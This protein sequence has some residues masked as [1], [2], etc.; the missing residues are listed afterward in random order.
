MRTGVRCVL[1]T[2]V[3]QLYGTHFTS[4]AFLLIIMMIA[5][6]GLMGQWF[7]LFST[8]N[9]SRW[10]P[11]GGDCGPIIIPSAGVLAMDRKAGWNPVVVSLKLLFST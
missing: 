10:K 11:L 2:A 3:R 4:W 9:G 1:L 6:I 7:D 8:N 5:L